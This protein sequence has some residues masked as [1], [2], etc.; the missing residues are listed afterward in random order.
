MM[1]KMICM[2]ANCTELATNRDGRCQQGAIVC[3]TRPIRRATT[4][5]KVAKESKTSSNME[6]LG[7][8]GKK[9]TNGLVCGMKNG[10]KCK[11]RGTKAQPSGA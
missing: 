5:Q 10:T 7:K 4:D 6:P 3:P 2:E 1:F 11:H 8:G 9:E